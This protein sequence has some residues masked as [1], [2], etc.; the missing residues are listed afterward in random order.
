[1]VLGEMLNSGVSLNC[2]APIGQKTVT[3]HLAEED[4]KKGKDRRRCMWWNW[5]YCRE[6]KHCSFSHP[7]GYC[8]D[9]LQG[10][11]SARGGSTLRHREVCKFLDS[12]AGCLWENTCEYFHSEEAVI[13]EEGNAGEENNASDNNI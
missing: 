7:S 1:M 2:I 12:E 10:R 11:C 3:A 5:G 13:L 9:H 8:W 6:K 4:E